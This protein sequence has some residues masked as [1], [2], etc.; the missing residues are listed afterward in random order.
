MEVTMLQILLKFNENVIK[1]IQSD[2]GEDFLGI[3][4]KSETFAPNVGLLIKESEILNYCQ[5]DCTEEKEIQSGR[6][7]VMAL[8]EYGKE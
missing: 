2:R 6:T 3:H 7:L 5:T 4:N 8:K 1:V